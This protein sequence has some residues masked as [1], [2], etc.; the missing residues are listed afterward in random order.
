MSRDGFWDNHDSA[1]KIVSKLKVAKAATKSVSE[2]GMGLNEARELLEMAEEE[3]ETALLGE[4]AG[5]IA[6][7]E[8]DFAKLRLA[9]VLSGPYDI[10]N[11]YLMLHAGAGGNESCDWVEMLKRLYERWGDRR[12]YKVTVVD[13]QR[14][15]EAGLR[16]VTL[17]FDGPYAFGYL[18]SEVGVHRLVRISPFDAM[19]KRHTSFASADVT[20]EVAEEE[21]EIDPKDL[22]IDTF[23]ASGAGGQHVNVTDSAVRITHIPTKL[24]VSCQNERS[25]HRNRA[26]AMQLLAGKLKV[27][28]DKEKEDEMSR[29]HGEKGDIGWGHQIRSYVL[30]PYQM[31]K[32]HRTGYETGNTEAVLDGDID[33]FIEEYLSQYALKDKD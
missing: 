8:K 17:K 21:I 10:S 22:R 30:H 4:L 3:E 7:L 2:F 6:A 5:T 20:P 19:G 33:D 16:S 27:R 14:E 18:K 29:I 26:I 32:D 15:A 12:R 31:V 25:Q 24:V 11:A 1:L 23:R 13:Y 28:A 9:A